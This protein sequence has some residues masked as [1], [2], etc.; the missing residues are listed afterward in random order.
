MT[1]K[2][3]A[4]I[5]ESFGD[6]SMNPV[7]EVRRLF[8]S[9]TPAE[10]QTLAKLTNAA[11]SGYFVSLLAT[12]MVATYYYKENGKEAE[13][14][15]LRNE[16]INLIYDGGDMSKLEEA[17]VPLMKD[18][19]FWE[20]Y[21]NSIESLYAYDVVF[22]EHFDSVQSFYSNVGK[23]IYSY[24]KDEQQ[25][26]LTD[27]GIDVALAYYSFKTM[28]L[29]IVPNHLMFATLYPPYYLSLLDNSP[30]PIIKN[31]SDTIIK[32][33]QKDVAFTKKVLSKAI[34]I[35]N[36]P[37]AM[38]DILLRQMNYLDR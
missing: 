8:R 30:A 16:V 35:E 37:K 10:E 18:G 13:A 2:E 14:K 4:W 19:D 7:I 20:Y 11:L 3:K 33:L 27:Y 23:A 15:E 5:K 17:L 24:V 22:R 1:S 12:G 9:K 29:P 26:N 6:I 38:Q 21:I 28:G 25:A 36:M 34:N 32:Y 31:S